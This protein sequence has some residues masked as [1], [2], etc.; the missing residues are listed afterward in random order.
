[1]IMTKEVE[2]VLK[3]DN[4]QKYEY[5]IKKIA[6]FEEVWSL[7]DDDGWASL[8]INDEI[9]FP[10]W[11]KSEFAKICISGEWKEYRCEAIDIDDFM[12]KWLPGLKEDGIRVTIMWHEGVGIDVDWDELSRDIESELEQYE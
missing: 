12:D 5:F 11:A 3:L 4:S 1:M 6:D 8:G 9:F 2:N 7:K 10:V